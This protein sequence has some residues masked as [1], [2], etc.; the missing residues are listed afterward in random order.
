MQK[1][2]GLYVITG[3]PG[4]GKTSLIEELKRSGFKAVIHW[5]MPG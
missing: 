5:L 2:T 4:T 1:Q 3:G